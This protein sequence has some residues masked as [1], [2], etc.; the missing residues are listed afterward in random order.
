MQIH[1]VV[2]SASIQ[3]MQ[4]HLF[5]KADADGNGNLNLEEFK[6]IGKNMPAGIQ[7]PAG[8]TDPSEIFNT[9]DADGNGELSQAELTNAPHPNFDAGMSQNLVQS[10][11][12][13][14]TSLVDAFFKHR[15]T[16]GEEKRDAHSVTSNQDIG[17]LIEQYL[18]NYLSGQSAQLNASYQV[19]V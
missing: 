2:S 10:L 17:S 16:D 6:A 13:G 12:D 5:S 1:S 19:T 7:R 3:Q 9:F 14:E 8:A 18:A 15:N 4:K 11:Q